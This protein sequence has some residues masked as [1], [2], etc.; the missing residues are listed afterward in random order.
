VAEAY[1]QLIAEGWLDARVGAGTWVAERPGRTPEPPAVVRVPEPALDLRGGIPDPSAFPRAEWAAAVRRALAE[2]PSDAFGYPDPRG[3]PRLRQA[4]AA[5]LARV[6]G[7]RTRTDDV[8]VGSGFGDLLARLCRALREQGVRRVAVE[9]F[10]H[11]RHRE[12]I[13]E[14]G[15]ETVT[16]PVDA[17]GADVDLLES[18]GA[19]AVLLT[20]AHQFPTG[21]ALSPER[22]LVLVRWARNNDGFVLEDDYDGEFRYDR[23]AVGA[24]QA[25]APEHVVYLGTASKSLAPAVGLAWAVVPGRLIPAAVRPAE[26]LGGGRDALGQLTLAAFLTSHRYDRNVRRLR[27]RYRSRRRDVI[28]EVTARLPGCRVSGLA[29]GLHCLLWLPEGVQEEDVCAEAAGRGLAVEGLSAF[30]EG[31]GDDRAA[32]VIGYGAPKP[33]LFRTALRAAVDSVAARTSRKPCLLQTRAAVSGPR[34]PN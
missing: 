2:A 8:L 1:T 29:A 16:L 9:E 5:Y 32:L 27:D 24:L 10:G 30:R 17:D 21:V 33:H 6:R 13:R 20:P 25:L 26:L 3:V 19:R 12:L 15:L 18:S 23:R 11:P 4:L 28:D 31:V 7:V 22:R 34:T 14:Q